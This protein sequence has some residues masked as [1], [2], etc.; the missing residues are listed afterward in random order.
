MP[1]EKAL[2]ALTAHHCCYITNTL[3]RTQPAFWDTNTKLQQRRTRG[4][5]ARFRSNISHIYTSLQSA[6]HISS[7]R[8]VCPVQ[9]V[10]G[11]SLCLAFR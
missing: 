4:D 2:Q 10:S 3:M 7:Q 5:G 6:A 8:L 1:A 11:L 9:N